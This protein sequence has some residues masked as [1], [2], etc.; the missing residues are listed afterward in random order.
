MTR[1][2]LEMIEPYL[3]AANVDLKSFSEEFYKDK[4]GGKLKPVLNNI[5]IMKEMGI[6][7][8]VT[9]LIIPGLNDSNEELKKIAK[10]LVTTGNDI[11]WHISAYYPQYKS[12]IPPTDINR[13]Q[14]AIN[15]GK[16][17][18]LKYVYGGN[19]SGSEYENTYCYKCG[20]LLIKRIGFSIT[21]NKIVNKAC[22]NCGLSIDG[23]FI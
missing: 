16:Q 18:G 12:N 4:I 13:I 3:D 22:P 1:Q 2:C 7:V 11:P 17:A 21:E 23:I 10:F 5:R 9:T 20:N 14:N 15:I 8:E 19:I 6:W